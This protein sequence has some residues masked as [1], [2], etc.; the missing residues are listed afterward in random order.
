M[1]SPCFPKQQH[2]HKNGCCIKISLY[3]KQH[4][5]HQSEDRVLHRAIE[6]ELSYYP[7]KPKKKNCSSSGLRSHITNFG[8]W[9][10]TV[11]C[12]RFC[13]GCRKFPIQQPCVQPFHPTQTFSMWCEP[14]LLY[15]HS[16][17]DWGNNSVCNIDWTYLKLF[18]LPIDFN[19]PKEFASAYGPNQIFFFPLKDLF[20]TLNQYLISARSKKFKK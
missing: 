7:K 6:L 8:S 4:H 19:I 13:W 18:S 12:H 3:F 1:R 17:S 16:H 5:K 11:I 10:A 2:A 14:L 20:Q 15:P 9:L